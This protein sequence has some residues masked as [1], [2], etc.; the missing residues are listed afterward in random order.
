MFGGFEYTEDD[1]NSLLEAGYQ[2]GVPMGG[3]LQDSGDDNP[4]TLMI[5]AKKDPQWANLDRIQVVKG[6]LQDGKAMEKV[7]DVGWSGD[8]K[9]NADG[10]LPP[11]GSTVNLEEASFENTIGAPELMTVWTDP[12]F[13]PAQQAFYYVR[14][15]QLPTAR[16]NLYDELR[17][18]GVKF[19]EGT[20]KQIVE[21]AWASPIWY[22]PN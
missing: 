16:W 10:K 8:R 4:V 21:R 6:W 17:N 5:H 13:D 2:K 9:L 18:P 12:D 22:E 14:V 19:P 7:Y 3:E 20:K 15:L 1:L 11:V